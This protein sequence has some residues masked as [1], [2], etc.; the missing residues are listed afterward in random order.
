M[1]VDPIPVRESCVMPLGGAER[2]LLCRAVRC[3]VV[4]VSMSMWV[5][6]MGGR[7]RP[8][9]VSEEV[10]HAAARPLHRG[11]GV[12]VEASRLA[13]VGDALEVSNGS[14]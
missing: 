1:T 14:L 13:D 6:L 4:P 8:V 7:C 5:A 12:G 9:S 10:C 2:I 3:R 11:D